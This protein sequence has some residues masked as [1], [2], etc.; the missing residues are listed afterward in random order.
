MSGAQA[1]R[2]WIL[3]TGG[4]GFIGSHLCDSLLAAGHAVFCLDDFSTGS[5]ANIAH[6]AGHPRFA[7][8]HHDVT[9]PLSALPALAGIYHLAC[10]AS[11]RH[12]QHDP[13]G[14]TRTAVLGTLNL[15][16]LARQR[17]VPL[18]FASTSEVYG[19]PQVHPQPES[20]TG[21]VN[22]TGPRACYDEGKRCAESLCFDYQRQYGAA[23][24][25]VRIFNTYGPRMQ[26]YDGRVIPNFIRQALAGEPITL[27]GDG[28][29]TR[30]FCYVDDLVEGLCQAMA[31]ALQGP[32]NLGNPETCSIAD[33]AQQ[34]LR[35]TGST[36]G[37]RY[38]PLP[39]DD[40]RQRCPD[41]TLAQR[42]LGWSPR[43]P[44]EEGLRRVLSNVGSGFALPGRGVSLA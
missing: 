14:T 41:I 19:D 11:P 42:S 43:V 37:L 7:C 18:L 26:P 32:L 35:L 9:V 38:L 21:Q 15:L 2:A 27:Y 3:V 28:R 33:L 36:A 29:Q 4:A 31:T 39:E 16:E 6:L 20:Y 10:P 25:V 12:Y 13:V 8:Q 23:V 24:R 34:I 22:C 40:P 17:R 1:P 30:S 44:L 5:R